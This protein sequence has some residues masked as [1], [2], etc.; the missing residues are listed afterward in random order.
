MPSLEPDDSPTLRDLFSLEG[1][2]SLVIGGSGYLGKEISFALA[3]LG[4]H[5]LIASRDIEKNIEFAKLL[6]AKFY[7]V[8]ATPMQVDITDQDSV[9]K[10]FGNLA[11]VCPNGLDVLVNCGWTGKKNN[12]DSISMEDWKYDLDVC[13]TGVFRIIKQATPFLKKK[14]GNILNIS[15]MYGHVAPDYRIYDS[16]K[17]ANPPSYGAA[18]AGIIQLTKYLSSFL[19]PHGIRVNCISPGPFPFIQTQNENPEFM[20]RL[21]EKNPLSRLGKPFEIKGAA[22]LLCTDAGSYMTGQNICVDGGWSVW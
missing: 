5:I 15:S 14:C 21:S 9:D 20:L 17:Y 16:E 13:L 11:Q 12:L 4:S 6:N 8:T 7:N 19:S 22:S 2:T 1:R 18:K 10:F 3:E